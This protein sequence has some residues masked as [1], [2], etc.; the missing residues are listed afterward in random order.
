[1]KIRVLVAALIGLLLAVG[2]ILAGCQQDE[3]DGS[4]HYRYE[5]EYDLKLYGGCD[6]VSGGRC[7]DVCAASQAQGS[8]AYD[9]K[10]NCH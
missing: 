5:Y 3:C 8:F 4:C 7:Y 9:V 10:C 1:M 2:M 6:V